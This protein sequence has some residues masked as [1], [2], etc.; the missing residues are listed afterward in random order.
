MLWSPV[1]EQ[2][3]VTAGSV[4][5]ATMLVAGP[6]A[7]KP[8]RPVSVS[9][10]WEVWPRQAAVFRLTRCR[11]PGRAQASDRARRPSRWRRR[12]QPRPGRRLRNTPDSARD[13]L[14]RLLCPP[15][16]VAAPFRVRG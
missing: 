6:R 8:V 1:E 4:R 9:L 10:R 14:V 2:L 3:A 16:A 12:A 13:A 7:R 5:E 11:Y 15:S